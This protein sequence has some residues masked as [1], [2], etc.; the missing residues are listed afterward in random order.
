MLKQEGLKMSEKVSLTDICHTQA[1]KESMGRLE[2][3]RNNTFTVLPIG[4]HSD[5][6]GMHLVMSIDHAHPCPQRGIH[7]ELKCDFTKVFTTRFIV[8][9]LCLIAHEQL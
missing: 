9:D 1:P 5:R 3:A 2:Y 6:V 4:R 8:S 7:G